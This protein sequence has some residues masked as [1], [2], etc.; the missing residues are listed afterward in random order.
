MAEDTAIVVAN[1]NKKHA[2]NLLL[3]MAFSA[4]PQRRRSEAV[5]VGFARHFSSYKSA[6]RG[7]PV[8]PFLLRNGNPRHKFLV[9]VIFEMYSV[10]GR[11]EF[12]R[13]S[14]RIGGLENDYASD[15]NK[16]LSGQP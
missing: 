2:M 9:M 10:F 16:D 4:I 5:R 14:F 13:K 1:E 8:S 11:P 6:L 12:C 7:A 3:L 15:E